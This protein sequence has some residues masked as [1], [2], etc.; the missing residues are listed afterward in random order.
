VKTC[1]GCHENLSL[2]EFHRNKKLRD[3]RET[4]CK[5]CRSAVAKKHRERYRGYLVAQTRKYQRE[6]RDYFRE[7]NR[8]YRKRKRETLQAGSDLPPHD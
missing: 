1:R 4:Q 3:G 7:Y 5:T 2:E 8:S 6:N